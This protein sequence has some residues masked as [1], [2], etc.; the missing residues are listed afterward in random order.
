MPLTLFKWVRQVS[1]FHQCWLAGLSAL[2]FV[3]G[4]APLEV[5]RQIVNAAVAGGNVRILILLAV[6]YFGLGIAEGLLKLGMNVYRGWVSENAVR[7]LRTSIASLSRFSSDGRPAKATGTEIAMTLSE[8][9]PIGNF[10]GSS[11]SEPFLQGGILISVFAYMVYLQPLMA[12]VAFGVFFPQFLLVPLMQR[13]L[14]RRV[15]VRIWTLRK[16]STGLVDDESR[17]A[18]T[19]ALQSQRVD[20]VFDLNMGIYKIKFSLNFAMNLLQ[21][22]GMA[23]ILGVGAVMVTAGRTDIGT[24]VAFAAG[25]AKINDPWGDLVTWYRDFRVVNERYRLI[26]GALQ[27]APIPGND[28]SN[29]GEL[30][31]KW[32][33]AGHS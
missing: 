2:L 28:A 7:W 5:Q 24:V 31:R 14:N 30:P 23:G 25:L 12:L 32:A 8:A 19:L 21:Y 3:V 6:A 1:G 10:V 26:S 20:R 29:V 17:A 27:T 11:V 4:L 13:A 16:I 18:S 22:A 33:K 9:E 15:G